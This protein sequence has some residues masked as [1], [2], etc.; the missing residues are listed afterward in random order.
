MPKREKATR[1]SKAAKYT[2]LKARKTVLAGYEI[3]SN[4]DRFDRTRTTP[5]AK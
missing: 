4:K 1:E 3:E 2:M 5:R